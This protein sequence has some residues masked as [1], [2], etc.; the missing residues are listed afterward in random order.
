MIASLVSTAAV[1]LIAL[2]VLAAELVLVVVWWRRGVI[3]LGPSVANI[4]S[5]ATLILALRAALLDQRAE[6]VA[7]WLGLGF[8]AHLADLLLRRR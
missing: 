5:G 1:T 6:I 3:R 2:A 7:L 4:L 8:V